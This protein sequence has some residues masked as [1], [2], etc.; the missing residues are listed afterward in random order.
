[1]YIRLYNFSVCNV[2]LHICDNCP[3]LSWE[4]FLGILSTIVFVD[5]SV[6]P[7]QDF[8]TFLIRTTYHTSDMSYSLVKMAYKVGTLFFTWRWWYSQFL[9]QCILV[10][11]ISGH[12]ICSKER[13]SCMCKF[14]C[15]NI[16]SVLEIE[17]YHI[18]DL[19]WQVTNIVPFRMKFSRGLFYIALLIHTLHHHILYCLFN[20]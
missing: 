17:K 6:T 16:F 13:P 18:S 7:Y 2:V 20:S 8:Y 10:S 15:W 12:W 14:K 19:T 11:Y 1:M 3:V 4:F 5:N 9:K